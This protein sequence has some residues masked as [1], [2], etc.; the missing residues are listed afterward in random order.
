[1]RNYY[2]NLRCYRPQ[3]QDYWSFHLTVKAFSL[4]GAEQQLSAFEQGLRIAG[5]TKVYLD[6]LK[7]HEDLKFFLGIKRK[8]GVKAPP[9]TEDEKSGNYGDGE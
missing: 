3:D 1:V 9:A 6:D 7:L 2:L 5:A 4:G 8:R